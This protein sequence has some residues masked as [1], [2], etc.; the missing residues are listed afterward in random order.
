[1]KKNFLLIAMLLAVLPSVMLAQ[2]GNRDANDFYKFKGHDIWNN[3]DGVYYHYNKV[4]TVTNKNTLYLVNVGAYEDGNPY[5]FFNQGGHWGVEAVLAEVGLP[6]YLKYITYTNKNGGAMFNQ[7]LM[8]ANDNASVQNRIINIV[9]GLGKDENGIIVDRKD[10]DTKLT[11]AYIKWGFYRCTDN[12]KDNLDYNNNEYLIFSVTNTNNENTN[13]YMVKDK[14]ATGP[15]ANVISMTTTK[16]NEKDKYARW[17][18]VSKADL[19]ERLGATAASYDDVADATFF[20]KD[21]QFARNNLDENAWTKTGPATINIGNKKYGAGTTNKDHTVGTIPTFDEQY[22]VE[23][24][25][26]DVTFYDLIY[27]EFNCAEIKGGNGSLIQ[28]LT[29]PS[30]KGWYMVTCQGFYRPGDDSNAQNAYLYV[31]NVKQTDTSKN[32]ST[33]KKVKLP[34][35]TAEQEGFTPENLTQA[36]I[37]FKEDRDNYYT[38]AMVW[39]DGETDLEVG[40]VVEN[41]NGN[42]SEWTAVDNFQLKYMGNDFLV[43]EHAKNAYFYPRNETFQTMVLERNFKLNQWNAITL[44]VDLTKS[45]IETAFGADAKLAK[46]DGLTNND[47]N[48]N[49]VTVDLNKFGRNEVVLEKNEIYVIYPTQEGNDELMDW[50]IVGCKDPLGGVVPGEG[51]WNYKT[52][53][54]LYII[55]MISLNATE[56]VREDDHIKDYNTLDPNTTFTAYPIVYWKGEYEN[57]PGNIEADDSKTR[58][59]YAISGNKLVHYKRSFPLKGLRWYLEYVDVS[60]SGKGIE[61]MS[62]DEDFDDTTTGIDTVEGAARE[63]SRKGIYTIDGKR[64][65]DSDTSNLPMGIYIVDGK[66]VVVY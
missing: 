63:T 29:K 19:I 22:T 24:K 39:L 35:I 16:P 51:N 30:R 36:G 11:E 27:G 12:D 26:K 61:R 48:I 9:R 46:L 34:L 47:K 58:Y 62:F 42:P 1:M 37:K 17:K 5:C 55:P 18:F 21:Q 53:S 31:R 43:S 25:N 49:F 13:R 64:M 54:P 52:R 3:N 44:P 45:Q 23:L 59:V 38:T 15:R 41:S 8:S 65:T 20:I 2:T 33:F 50:Y 6:I 28:T 40:I 7:M 32:T 14:N 4:Q 66:K 60:A 56:A 10:A 57:G